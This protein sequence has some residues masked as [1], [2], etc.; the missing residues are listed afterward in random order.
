MQSGQVRGPRGAPTEP[1]KR[2]LASGR[3]EIKR[4]PAGGESKVLKI[5]RQQRGTDHLGHS[6]RRR[7]VRL[8]CVQGPGVFLDDC[9]LE[10]VPSQASKN[11]S[12]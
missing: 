9:G 2:V 4:E 8:A 11:W 7:S 10:Q 3:T 5:Y 6:G 1:A 12:E